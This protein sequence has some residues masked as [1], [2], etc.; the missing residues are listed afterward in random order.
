MTTLTKIHNQR[1]HNNKIK[2]TGATLTE[3]AN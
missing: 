2:N 3:N 1:D